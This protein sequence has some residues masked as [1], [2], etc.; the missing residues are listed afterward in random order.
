M[1]GMLCGMNSLQG[2]GG[3][4]GRNIW[5]AATANKAVC[6]DSVAKICCRLDG[7]CQSTY[8]AFRV[9]MHGNLFDSWLAT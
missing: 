4:S 7:C 6:N 8:N 3:T 9:I 1:L 2:P 5:H